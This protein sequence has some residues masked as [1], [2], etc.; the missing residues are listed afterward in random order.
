MFRREKGVARGAGY[1]ILP[2]L[3]HHMDLEHAGERYLKKAVRIAWR[4]KTPSDLPAALM[5]LPRSP[6]FARN[7]PLEAR[8]FSMPVGTG[9]E[10]VTSTPTELR[11]ATRGQVKEV[12]RERSSGTSA[13]GGREGP[14]VE[15]PKASE[16]ERKPEL[17]S[18][19]NPRPDE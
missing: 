3:L 11:Q 8:S 4:A 13:Q 12:I 15:A 14:G 17:D 2:L 18:D 9:E 1:P 6:T 7:P 10:D 19:R 16:S 5:M